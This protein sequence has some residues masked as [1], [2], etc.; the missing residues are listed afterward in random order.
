MNV[1]SNVLK[2]KIYDEKLLVLKGNWLNSG[3]FVS[4]NHIIV[5]NI[6]TITYAILLPVS[7]LSDNIHQ[8]FLNT[9]TTINEWS[10]TKNPSGKKSSNKPSYTL[11]YLFP[12]ELFGL[13]SK[14]YQKLSKSLEVC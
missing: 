10:L 13:Q 12:L 7:Y 9:V 1:V 4:S 8:K 5:K 2:W 11:F 6:E 3:K 14:Q